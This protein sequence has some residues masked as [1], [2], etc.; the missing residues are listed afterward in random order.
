MRQ[1]ELTGKPLL[2]DSHGKLIRLTDGTP[3][4]IAGSLTIGS[5]FKGAIVSSLMYLPR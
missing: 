2:S 4:A 5:S 3:A 1:D